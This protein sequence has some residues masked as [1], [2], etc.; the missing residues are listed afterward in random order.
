MKAI[1]TTDARTLLAGELSAG[2]RS[3]GWGWAG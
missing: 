3:T 1:T 2:P